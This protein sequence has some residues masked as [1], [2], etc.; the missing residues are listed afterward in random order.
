MKHYTNTFHGHTT[1][2]VEIE[3]TLPLYQLNFIEDMLDE[4]ARGPH[5]Y[6]ES[7]TVINKHDEDIR[8]GHRFVVLCQQNPGTIDSTISDISEIVSTGSL[9]TNTGHDLLAKFKEETTHAN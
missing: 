4:L 3:K 9:L 1:V 8:V 6:F 2:V 7:L 5:T